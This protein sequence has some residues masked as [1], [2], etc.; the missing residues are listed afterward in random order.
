MLVL[1]VLLVRRRWEDEGRLTRGG[2]SFGRLLLLLVPLAR[3]PCLRPLFFL[4]VNT[5]VCSVCMVCS[6]GIEIEIGIETLRG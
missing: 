3:A 4:L 2:P 1:L 6:V 5:S